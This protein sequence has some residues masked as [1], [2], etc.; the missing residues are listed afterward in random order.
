RYEEARQAAARAVESVRAEHGNC[1]QLAQ[2]IDTQG[3]IALAAGDPSGATELFQQAVDTLRQ[4]GA[5]DGTTANF[6]RNLGIAQRELGRWDE[7]R[8]SWE[9]ALQI[10]GV[11]DYAFFDSISRAELNDLITSL[12]TTA[13]AAP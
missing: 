12:P 7:A 4:S 8:A 11:T 2:F 3:E 9:T 10:V 6:L 5:W 1:Y 13:T